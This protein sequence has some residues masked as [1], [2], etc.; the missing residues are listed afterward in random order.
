MENESQYSFEIVVID[1][2]IGKLVILEKK[3][4]FLPNY[5]LT[6]GDLYIIKKR[7]KQL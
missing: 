3:S 6:I 5:I 2:F 7:T 4:E 1:L